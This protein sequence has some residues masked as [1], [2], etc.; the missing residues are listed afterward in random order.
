MVV[1]SR[2]TAIEPRKATEGHGNCNGDHGSHG[3]HGPFRFARRDPDLAGSRRS[4]SGFVFGCSA[5]PVL[6]LGFRSSRWPSVAFRGSI[7]VGLALALS[8][9]SVASVVP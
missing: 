3:S 4:F 6:F 2:S 1:S 7:A 8:V 9:A 5:L